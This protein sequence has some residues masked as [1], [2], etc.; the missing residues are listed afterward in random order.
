MPYDLYILQSNA[1]QTADDVIRGLD[2]L[3][4]GVPYPFGEP[5]PELER[6]AREIL[7]E[8]PSIQTLEME[9]RLDESIWN[10][11]FDTVDGFLHLVLGLSTDTQI[12]DDISRIARTSGFV[13]F[14]P[15]LNQFREQPST[16]TV[17]TRS[18][19]LGIMHSLFRKRKT[20]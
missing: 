14:D 16:N 11:D 12:L 18:G 2:R 10:A 20:P 13:V 19:L 9:D 1:C 4:G 7:A 8:Y 6:C 15:Q 17:T 3:D 5:T